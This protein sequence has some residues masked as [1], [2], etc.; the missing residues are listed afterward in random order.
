MPAVPPPAELLLRVNLAS[1]LSDRE[2]ARLA[3]LA[4]E[5]GSMDRALTAVIRRGL[6]GRGRGAGGGSAVPNRPASRLP[7]DP[8]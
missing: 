5:E 2:L 7:T 1:V 4:R 6:A 8:A 3:G